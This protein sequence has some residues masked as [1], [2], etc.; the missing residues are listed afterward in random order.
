MGSRPAAARRMSGLVSGCLAARE[1]PDVRAIGPDV[2][3]FRRCRMSGLGRPDV[4]AGLVAFVALGFGG[5]GF[6]G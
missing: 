4:Q 6:S 3:A 2:R 1:E 5:A